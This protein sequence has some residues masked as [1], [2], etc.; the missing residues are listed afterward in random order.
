MPH[1]TDDE[2][3]QAAWFRALG[4]AGRLKILRALAAGGRKNVG[5]VADAVGLEYEAVSANLA[6]L[7]TAGLVAAE[8]DGQFRYYALVGAKVTKTA[9]EF[10]HPSGLRATIPLAG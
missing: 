8:R 3:A 4:N 5:E 7:A 1:P 2:R 6:I 10:A 9:V